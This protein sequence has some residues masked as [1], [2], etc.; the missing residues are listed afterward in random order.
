M[1]ILI[2]RYVCTPDGF[3]ENIL[4]AF[5]TLIR[6]IDTIDK[7]DKMKEK[8]PH[9]EIMSYDENSI[10]Y[11]G[12]I[13]THTHLEFSSNQTTLNYGDFMNWLDSV[14]VNRDDLVAQCD[15]SVM[16]DAC[17]SMLKSGVTTFGAISSF[18]SELEVVQKTP[19]RVVLFNELIGSAPAYVDVLYNDFLERV[20]STLDCDKNSRVYPAIAIHSPYSVHPVILDKA[21]AL[22]KKHSLVLSTHFMESRYER[23]WLDKGEGKFKDFFQKYFNA[24]APVTNAK[25]FISAFD[26]YPTHFVHCVYATKEELSHLKKHNHSIGHAPRSNRYLGCDRLEIE[27]IDMPMTIVTDGLSSNDSLNIFDELRASLF[28]HNHQDLDVLAKRLID[29]ITSEGADILGLNCGRIE[30]GKMADFAVLELPQMPETMEKLALWTILHS[31]EVV[32]LYING[33]KTI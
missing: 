19:Q 31:K 29:S 25:D 17:N 21:I 26:N 22:A 30:V 10:L 14:I 27:N 2:C 24:S 1:K 15:N 13:N 7:L 11:A 33:E 28:I 9:A 8:Y 18:G 6:E 32:G 5:D 12:F 16:L 3:K 20:Q 23:E 4:V